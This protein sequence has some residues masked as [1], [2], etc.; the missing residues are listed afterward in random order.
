MQGDLYSVLGVD[1]EASERA[2]QGAYRKLARQCHPDVNS[3]SDAPA[4]FAAVSQAYAVIGN[5]ERRETYD[6]SL[7]SAGVVPPPPIVAQP[8]RCT[9]CGDITAQ[10]RILMFRSTIG[11]L[12]WS[13]V[14][15][16]E[17]VYCSRCARRSGL[18]AS[19]VTAI[20]GW[21]AAPAGPFFAAWCILANAGG[22]SRRPKADRRFA[23]LNAQA[24]LERR[25]LDLAYAL[26]L[27]AL[28]GPHG[29]NGYDAAKA[30]SILDQS[31]PRDAH[32]RPLTLKNPWRPD[33]AYIVAH[34]ILLLAVPLSATVVV[35][36]AYHQ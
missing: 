6:R 13:R 4:R 11:I 15:R 1:R 17:G 3:D 2:I 18:S 23:L 31:K 29:V 21:W 36:L 24:F 32:R 28:S 27:E 33:L 25:N 8:I 9:E 19:L 12:V 35:W 16:I 30:R 34:I 22:G 10:P 20:W 26:A 5:R 14:R 7:R